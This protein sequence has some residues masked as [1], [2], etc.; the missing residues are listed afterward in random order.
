MGKDV[1]D[2]PSM[3]TDTFACFEKYMQ[4]ALK[5]EI[6]SELFEKYMNECENDFLMKRDQAIKN[7]TV[8]YT[9]IRKARENGHSCK[10]LEMIVQKI[11]DLKK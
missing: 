6:G 3:I 10:T 9:I 4:D 1:E 11:V 7:P 2:W 8:I 5:N